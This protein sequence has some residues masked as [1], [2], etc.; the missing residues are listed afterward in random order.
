MKATLIKDIALLTTA[1]AII[2]C[3][4][5]IPTAQAAASTLHAKEQAIVAQYLPANIPTIPNLPSMDQFM[6]TVSAS[7][8]M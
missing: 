8:R 7:D 5:L 2:G 3:T 1:A 6:N 4:A